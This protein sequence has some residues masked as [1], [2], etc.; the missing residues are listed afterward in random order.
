MTTEAHLGLYCCQFCLQP[1]RPTFVYLCVLL[2]FVPL[3]RAERRSAE[4]IGLDAKILL[5]TLQYQPDDLLIRLTVPANAD[6]S[7][8]TR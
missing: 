8:A 1:I 3:P 4:C 5:L 2:G 7:A 6:S